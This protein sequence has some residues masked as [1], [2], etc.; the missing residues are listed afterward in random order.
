MKKGLLLILTLALF[1]GVIFAQ[2]Y[3]L[4]GHQN[5]SVNKNIPEKFRTVQPTRPDTCIYN[6]SVAPITLLMSYY[7]Y[8]IGGYNDLPI[9]VQ[10]DPL[11]GGYFMTFHGQRT[12]SGQRRV[13][14]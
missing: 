5:Q 1:V 10:P 12:A 6:F 11:Y 7:D 9:N 13:F 2:D 3:M 8:M 4:P 14:E